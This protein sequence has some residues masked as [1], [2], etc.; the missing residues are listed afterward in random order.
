MVVYNYS[1]MLPI[2]NATRRYNLVKSI[3]S[4]KFMVKLVY[5]LGVYP[6]AISA[7]KYQVLTFFVR[8]H[9]QV[10]SG[11]EPGGY[12]GGA[13]PRN[14]RNNK[15]EKRREGKKR[16]KREKKREKREKE[17]RKREWEE[18][19]RGAREVIEREEKGTFK[20]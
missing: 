4:V 6:R 18:G 11:T 2:V 15:K 16:E 17:G 9:T 12:Y 8:T 13:R 7:Y 3:E 1:N 19:R 20:F 5:G 10:W 14:I